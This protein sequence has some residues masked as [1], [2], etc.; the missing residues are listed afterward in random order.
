MKI[1]LCFLTYSN[2]SQPKLWHNIINSNKDKLNVYIHNKIEFIDNEYNLHKYC[3]DNKVTTKYGDKSII[4]ATLTLFK[5]AFN[6]EENEF[7]ILLSDNCIPIYNFDYI[8]NKIFEINNNII[9][10]NYTCLNNQYRFDY[11]T[12]TDFFERDK[13]LNDSQWLL[14]N[15]VTTKWFLENNFLHLFGDNFF[16]ADE[17]YFGN[18]CNKYHVDF[19]NSLLTFVN[20]YELSDLDTDRPF[21]KTY[22]YLTNEM[23]EQIKKNTTALFMRKIHKKCILPSYFDDLISN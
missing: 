11:L 1:A 14:L 4:D 13:F 15:R 3:I 22:I 18:L 9:F 20:W 7:F 17:H 23:V 2:V 21:P 12:N 5:E 10:T 8:Y 19:Q 6:N 16:A